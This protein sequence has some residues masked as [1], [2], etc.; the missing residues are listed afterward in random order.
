MMKKSSPERVDSCIYEIDADDRIV[1]CN[2]GWDAFALANGGG[3]ITFE[4][5]DGKVLWDFVA[6]P[7]S[8][9]LY[10]RLVEQVRNGRVVEF[11]LRCDSPEI[12]RL[13][14]MRIAMTETARVRFI[15]KIKTLE[16]RSGEGVN[17]ADDQTPLLVCSW[18]GRI[19]VDQEIW[20]DVEVAIGRLGIFERS[21]PPVV[22]HG[23]CT[24]CYSKITE[25][26][27]TID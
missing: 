16:L 21:F 22:S 13:L 1:F 7:S 8:K 19:N 14:E 25:L 17:V 4:K 2:E 11:S 12:S 18:C 24:D 15:T 3:G 9:D 10:R 20:Q 6:D 26:L 5:I 27:A 23:I